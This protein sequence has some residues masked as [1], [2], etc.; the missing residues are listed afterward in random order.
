MS[1][2]K[3]HASIGDNEL[4]V[5]TDK[6]RIDFSKRLKKA[7]AEAGIAEW[8]AGSFLA[9]TTG[10]TPKAASKW[11]N[12]ETMPGRDNMLAIAK[13][14]RVNV[15][16][17]QY[18]TPSVNERPS[19]YSIE[20]PVFS[21]P[22]ISEV[23]A[24]VWCESPDEFQPGDAE[25]WLPRPKNAGDKTFALAVDGDS[26]T[27]QIPG[28]RS[29]PHGTIIYV[30]PDKPF[31]NGSRVVGRANGNYTFKLFVEDAGKK[32]LKPINPTYDKIDITDDVHICG[33]VIGSY[34]PE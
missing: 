3:V 18:G 16:W 11:M 21:I 15:E 1:E 6:L 2:L 19:A 30:D 9:K 34:L 27:S 13:E 4:M 22:L 5:Q 7:L 33:V 29:Y 17:L 20:A 10:K 14:L 31:A 23:S 12:A 24:G 32:Y 26:M 25:E 8:G 28:Q